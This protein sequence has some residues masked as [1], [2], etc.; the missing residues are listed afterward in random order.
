MADIDQHYDI[1]AG[2]QVDVSVTD[3]LDPAIHFHDQNYIDLQE[4]L[5]FPEIASTREMTTYETYDSDEESLLPGGRIW[6]DTEIVLGLIPGDEGI[7]MLEKAFLTKDPL[8]FRCHYLMTTD[9]IADQAPGTIGYYKI[10]DAHVVGESA[11]GAPDAA[12]QKKFTLSIVDMLDTGIARKGEALLTGDWGIGAGTSYYP[13]V[14]DHN[15][16]SG[17]RFVTFS[18]SSPENP[19]GVDTGAL[20]V[21]G[22]DNQGWQMIVNPNG[23]PLMRIRNL[24]PTPQPWTKI[25]TDQDKPT[26]ADLNAV[27]LRGGNLAVMT[28]ELY[29]PELRATTFRFCPIPGVANEAGLKRYIQTTNAAGE[30]CTIA[31]MWH[32]GGKGFTEIDNINATV[33]LKD[34][35]E[36]VFSPLNKPTPVDVGAVNKTGDTMTGNLGIKQGNTGIRFTNSSN[37]AYI[38]GGNYTTA[39]AADPAIQAMYLSGINGAALT[40]FNIVCAAANYANMKINGNVIYHA[41][42]KPTPAEIGAIDLSDTIDLGTF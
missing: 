2:G 34:R 24:S 18:G 20:A 32:S 15:K 42:R 14:I 37:R 4:V 17:N 35:G 5:S 30:A 3:I 1:F 7:E 36:L 29:S 16:L 6:N 9:T 31:T 19:F 33:S 27:D 12:V 23:K 38:Q 41:G 25:Y 21:Q 22:N 39:G 8:R 11:S 26:P 13:G 10:F 28:G 40:E